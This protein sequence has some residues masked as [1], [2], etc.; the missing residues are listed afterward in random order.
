VQQAQPMQ[1]AQPAAPVE[2]PI[3]QDGWQWDHEAQE[4]KPL[5]QFQQPPADP[6]DPTAPH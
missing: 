6:T 3:I 4:W 5:E 1:Q 2:Q